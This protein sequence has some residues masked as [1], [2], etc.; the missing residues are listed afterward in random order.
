VIARCAS[1]AWCGSS[2]RPPRAMPLC[3]RP[4]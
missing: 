1:A 3:G 2:C 4:G